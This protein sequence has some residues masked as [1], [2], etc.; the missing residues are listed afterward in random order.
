MLPK[1]V[2]LVIIIEILVPIT[3]CDELMVMT[4]GLRYEI[5]KTYTN[6]GVCWNLA[7]K[8]ALIGVVPTVATT[9]VLVSLLSPITI[10]AEAVAAS[11]SSLKT[12]TTQPFGF[13][14]GTILGPVSGFALFSG[15]INDWK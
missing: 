1:V 7:L 8:V 10:V 2:V 5:R 13:V 9:K 4:R 6:A 11:A 15:A 12:N 3:Q 14:T